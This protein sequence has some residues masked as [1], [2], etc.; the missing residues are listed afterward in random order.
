MLDYYNNICYTNSMKLE[1]GIRISNGFV[2]VRIMHDGHL[3]CKHI[4]KDSELTRQLASIHLA[5]K[6]KE[7]L[8]G[9][10]GIK[11]ELKSKT[12][13]EVSDLYL[14]KW[15]Q[16]LN[17]EGAPAHNPKQV[18]GIKYF[19]V[20]LNDY[21]GKTKYHEIRS[22]DVQKFRE[23]R[24]KKVLGTSVNRAQVVLSSIFNHIETWVNTE[25]IKAFKLPTDPKTGQTWNPCKAVEKAPNRQRQRVISVMEL[26]ALK[27]SCLALNDHDLWEICE[28]ALKSLLRKKD[29]FALES[30]QIDGLQAK[31]GHPIKLPIQVLKPLNYAN[32]RKRFEA[33]RKAARIEDFQ[34]RDL[35][36][37]GANLLKM[38]NHSNKMISEFLGHAST[39]TTEIYMI[40]DVE[41]L[42]PLAKDLEDM[43]KDL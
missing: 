35:R 10:F 36:K 7:I 42:K 43:L 8:L 26:K 14:T 41:H 2:Q 12:F 32:F 11:P 33:A 5:E 34:F 23:E 6:R 20:Q 18:Q 30:G 22:L 15:S 4:G 13:S 19:L 1:K 17:S 37:T 40:K 24:L 39:Q 38:R 28:M 25:E 27:Q 31:T 21:F 16:Q 9:K 29:L 3:Y